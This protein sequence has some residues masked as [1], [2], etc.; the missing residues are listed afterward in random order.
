MNRLQE[1][2]AKGL[3]SILLSQQQPP[4][5]MRRLIT[6]QTV[7]GQL[8]PTASA[9][10]EIAT[11]LSIAISAYHGYKKSYDSIAW[12]AVW[13]VLGGLFPIITPTIAVLDGYAKP[14][15]R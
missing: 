11:P 15:R 7:T 8:S 1:L 14:D 6:G 13:G 4:R 10:W 5:D 9:L 12:G 2:S 3:N